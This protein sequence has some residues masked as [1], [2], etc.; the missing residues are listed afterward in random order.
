[1]L[2]SQG[3]P[4]ILFSKALVGGMTTLALVLLFWPLIQAGLR[5]AKAG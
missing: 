5:K 1:M 2:M 3:N 4:S